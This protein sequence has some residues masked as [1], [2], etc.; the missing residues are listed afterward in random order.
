[1][2]VSTKSN[3]GKWLIKISLLA[4]AMIP[5]GSL[6]AT[7]EIVHADHVS[8][9]LITNSE[10]VTPGGDILLGLKQIPAKGWHTYWVNP[11]DTGLAASVQWTLPKGLAAGPPQWPTP[12]KLAYAGM[13]TY[14]YES[15]STLII[16]LHNGSGLKAGATVPLKAQLD[17]LVCAEICVPESLDLSLNLKV[18]APPASPKSGPDGSALQSALESLP[19]PLN[20][21]AS[22]TLKDGFLKLAFTR[23]PAN[24]PAFPAFANPNGVYAFVTPE[25]LAE[26]S[27]PEQMAVEGKGFSLTVKTKS[28][29]L[30][31]DLSAV[32][33]FADG[34]AWQVRLTP[35]LMALSASPDTAAAPRPD[36]SLSGLIVAMMLAF[37]GGLVLNLMPCVFPILSIKLLALTRAGHGKKLARSEAMLYGAGAIISFLALALALNLAGDLGASLG[38]GFQLQSPYVTGFLSLLLLLVALNMSGLFEIGSSLQSLAGGQLTKI[39]HK[40]RLSAFMTGVLAV[41]IAAPCSAPFMAA[42]IGVALAQGGL[43]SVGIFAALGIGFAAPFIALT[44]AITLMPA[45]ARH[46]PKPG[47]WMERVRKGLALPMYAAALWMIWVFGQ[48]VSRLGFILLL[49]AIGL[50]ALGLIVTR[51]PK[52]AKQALLGFSLILSLTAAAQQDRAA[53]AAAG[54]QAFLPG[55]I[56]A[57]RAEKKPILVDLTAAWCITCKVNEKIVLSDPG[58]QKAIHDTGTVY[59]VGDWTHQDKS[60]SDYLRQFGRSGVPLYVYYGPHSTNPI[61]LPQILNRHELINL[62]RKE[63]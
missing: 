62:L 4:L 49:A 55:E 20:V 24:S 34:K 32:L 33:K 48:Q 52:P 35:T 8:A 25:G 9:Q 6:A 23:P 61:V 12:Q 7:S 5:S 1:M 17:T 53:T 56:A 42:A 22:A 41:V 30:P 38:W 43:A 28:A 19:Q 39:Q 11:G 63:V 3:A 59:M 31:Q 10:T 50:L 16:R 37:A 47:I 2:Y 27:A 54:Y 44:F 36:I 40:P 57:L 18:A 58:V 45:L 15:P 29:S 46:M 60:I 13:M 21:A 51:L 14:G 26:P